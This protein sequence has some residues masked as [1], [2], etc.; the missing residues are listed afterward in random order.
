MTNIIIS[1]VDNRD[2]EAKDFLD[3]NTEIP[4]EYT[5][6]KTKVRCQWLSSQCVCYAVTQAMSQQEQLKFGSYNLYSPGLLYAN[7]ESDDYQGE[8]WFIRKALKQLHK[9]GTCNE[10]DFPYPESYKKERDKFLSDKENLLKKAENH[11]IKAYYRC[12]SEDEIKRCIMQKGCVI[13]QSRI[14]KRFFLTSN[15]TKDTVKTFRG[16]HVYIIIGWDEQGW[17]I[18]DS[19]SILRPFLGRPHISYDFPLEE[20]WGI[21]L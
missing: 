15:I 9:Y 6:P 5:A 21:E 14:N 2:F 11:K 10:S 4:K 17:I 12:Y 19:Y 1:P 3:F 16:R 18:Q 7:R 20:Y 13:T 8:G